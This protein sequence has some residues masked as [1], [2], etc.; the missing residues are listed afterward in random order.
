MN[1]PGIAIVN[2]VLTLGGTTTFCLFLAAALRRQNVPVKVF[3]FTR[4]HAMREDFE[5][6]GVPVELQDERTAIY[7][8][9]QMRVV[10]SIREFNPR[11][12]FA[13][14]GCETFETLRY[15]PPGVLRV[16]MLHDDLEIIFNLV[17]QYRD[18]M[19][20][21]AAVSASIHDRLRSDFP[22]LPS[23]YLP[24]G[25][26]KIDWVHEHDPAKPLKILFFGRFDHEQKG[27]LLF[28]ALYQELKKRNVN[29]TW[30]I[31]GAGPD[32]PELKRLMEGAV[33]SGDVVF[34]SPVH[35]RELP[36]IVREHDIY[37][38]TS[39]H[40][41][42]PLTL[43]E[44]MQSGLAPVCSDI[45]CLVQEVIRNGENGF[46]IRK[47]DVGGFADAI[48]LLGADRE[49]LRQIASE[50]KATIVADYLSDQMARRYV[51]FVNTHASGEP[52]RW[53]TPVK[54][55]GIRGEPAWRYSFLMRSI[56]RLAKRLGK[57]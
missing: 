13:V 15:M 40:E 2:R 20:C 28:P 55:Q 45:P 57:Q 9:R 19:D 42:G 18:C 6:A 54:I 26:P 48:A 37:L 16:G 33:A 43:L 29:F 46:R 35:Y 3:T 31:H 22:D 56:R 21:A 11:A 36:K 39:F 4:E 47:G 23:V 38:M 41:A 12:V 34:S 52:P 44:A 25:V 10:E 7:E 27:V 5:D 50:A 17:R 51:D 1:T 14:L 49:K 53:S 24:H 32:G 30:T 8:D